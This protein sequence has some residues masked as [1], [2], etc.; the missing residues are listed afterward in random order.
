MTTEKFYNIIDNV[1]ESLDE[2]K[3]RKLASTMFKINLA[4][5]DEIQI[6]Y[7]PNNIAHLLGINIDYLRAAGLYDGASYDV[8]EKIIDNPNYLLRQI[9]SG[10][11]KPEQIFSEY[12][13]EKNSIFKRSAGIQ[14]FD[15]EFIVKYKKDRNY[16]KTYELDNGYYFCY[17]NGN[18]ISIVGYAKNDNGVYNPI[19][20]RSYEKN[21]AE[22][23]E[24]LTRL[25]ENQTVTIPIYMKKNVISYNYDFSSKPFFY[26]KTQ[27]GTKLRTIKR[28]A[29][30]YGATCDTIAD[31]IYHLDKVVNIEDSE[32]SIVDFIN[33][34]CNKI[35]QKRVID[36]RSVESKFGTV[37][38]E[39]LN[40]MSAANDLISNTD[41]NSSD[42]YKSLI[43]SCNTLKEQV[44]EKDSLIKTLKEKNNS[45]SVENEVLK[46]ENEEYKKD[47]EEIFKILTKTKK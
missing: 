27:K 2:Y 16:G 43:T 4:N 33:Y 7:Y 39:M 12:V 3:K 28:Y 11:I 44:I 20:S 17:D 29:D 6:K 15:I 47:S 45:L 32:T 14:F 46:E 38:E 25:L 10:I 42:S 40:L 1:E 8:L 41:S 13:L 37:T 30:M 35:N 24:F 36:M 23:N 22:T 26:N 31:H 19:T 34:I 9:N 21:S 18:T 5:D